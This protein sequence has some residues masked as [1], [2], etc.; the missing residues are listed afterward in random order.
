M[1][2][3]QVTHEERYHIQALRRS[4][5]RPAAIARR[6]HRARSTVIRELRRNAGLRKWY[7]ADRAQARAEVRRSESRRNRRIGPQQWRDVMR[8]LEAEWSPKQIAGY[9]RRFGQ[10]RICHGTIYN[11]IWLDRAA[12][13]E[14]CRF[15][16][17]GGRRRIRYGRRT[18]RGP[19]LGGRSIDTRPLR[20]LRRRQLGHWEI[21]TMVGPG[22]A[23]V[24]TLVERKTGYV[25]IGKVRSKSAADITRRAIALIRAHKHKMRTITA[26]NGTEFA[27]HRRIEQLTGVR[28][29]FAHPYRAWER[30][31]NENTN[32]LIRQYWPK[33]QDFSRI[34]QYDCNAVAR[35]LNT[36]P[37]ERLNWRTPEEC[38]A[39]S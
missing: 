37:R 22:P 25:L 5:L 3:S 23:A 20:I 10:L 35:K 39:Q 15:L 29:Y 17:R 9:L 12:G 32:G 38:Y 1:T 11:H 24:I 28:F 33:G 36:R 19:R 14:L 13:G 27:G 8:L 7:D 6:L 30:G 18:P 31:T 16:R 34:T 21:D 2:Y 26:D 4:G